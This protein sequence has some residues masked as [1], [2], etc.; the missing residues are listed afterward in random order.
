MV[1][2]DVNVLIYAFREEAIEHSSCSEFVSEMVSGSILFLLPDMVWSSFLRIT[3]N[4]KL[5][6]GKV[7]LDKSLAY[8]EPLMVEYCSK[9]AKEFEQEMIYSRADLTYFWCLSCKLSGT[10]K[11]KISILRFK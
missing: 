1:L 5:F 9:R 8:T 3:T 11:K 2:P 10:C 4:E 7:P 6:Y